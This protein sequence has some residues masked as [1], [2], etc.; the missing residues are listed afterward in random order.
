MRQARAI[1]LFSS[2][3]FTFFSLCAQIIPARTAFQSGLANVVEHYPNQFKNLAGEVVTENPQ[4][5]DYRSVITLKG[6]EE[7]TV[8]KFSAKGKEVYS[9]QAVMLTTEDFEEALKKYKSLYNSIQRL[10]V[11]INGANAILSSEYVIPTEEKKFNS[12]IFTVSDKD[13]NLKKMKVELTLQNE[14]LEWVIK[15]LVYEKEREDDERG[16][17]IDQ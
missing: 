13:E 10:A 14:L 2:L 15:V 7:C 1:F 17:I 4:S 11:Q 8:T 6:S 9:W 12:I 3:C 16:E 5:T